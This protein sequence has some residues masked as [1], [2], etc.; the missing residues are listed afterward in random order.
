ME[1]SKII[2]C[3]PNFSEGRDMNIIKQ[4]TDAIESVDG[5]RLLDVDPGK[6]TNRTV[7]TFVGSPEKVCEA[8]FLAVKKASEVIDMSKHSGAHPRMGATDVCPLVPVSG[9][10]ME[11][12]V[13]YARGLAERIGRELSIPV[14][15][16]EEAAF[17]EKRK[18]LATVR[19]GEY[20]GL[21]KKLSDA[22]WKPDF[23][24]ALFNA[25]T[26]AVIVGARDFLV[27][28]NVN[29]NTTSTRRANAIAF[30]IRERGRE[31]KDKDGKVTVIPGS[32]KAVKAIGWYIPEYGIAQISINLTNIGITPMHIA[33]DEVC[34]KANERGLR[35]TGS[36]LV[37]LV[38]LKAI[39]DAGRYFLHKQQRSAGV[40]DEELIKIAVKSMGLDELRPFKPEEKI[41][42]YLLRDTS[43]KRLVDM[44]LTDFVWETSSESPAPGGGSV[45]ATMGALGSALGTMVANLS[46]HKRGWDDRWKE[47]SDIAEE[48]VIIQHRLLSLIDEDTNAFN[49]IMKAFELPRRTDEEKGRRTAAIEQ[50][51][52]VATKV[53][54]DVMKESF[55]SYELLK[56]MVETGN[57][58]SIT[59]AGVGVL[60]TTACIRGAGL[61]VRINAAG[62]KD[63]NAAGLLID[64]ANQIE[65]KALKT[66]K[67]I[68][69]IVNSKI[70]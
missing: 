23:G 48:G 21:E 1:A 34:K 52:L 66:E 27:A 47:F 45:S 40:S 59:D 9:I 8:A 13:A 44:T 31:V 22:E 41:I 67:E 70:I 51:T 11:E 18:N 56:K 63:K 33:F 42:E 65:N 68:I 20:E 30:D 2:E 12:T 55:K 32:L 15:C 61:N 54:L 64:E 14:Y 62:L 25:R 58:N 4:I 26:G 10:T 36:E 69:D 28:Y 29:L 49:L 57:P 43:E 17:S 19:S 50:A 37:G 46:S 5:V 6:D 35:A 39:L 3:V 38:P 16:Y 7:V 60:A 53:P 24:P